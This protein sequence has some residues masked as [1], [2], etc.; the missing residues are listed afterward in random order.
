MV[1]R[2]RYVVRDPRFSRARRFR[3]TFRVDLLLGEDYNILL[4]S[5]HLEW[6]ADHATDIAKM[7]VVLVAGKT[8]RH[9]SHP[10]M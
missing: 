2:D 1:R 10:Q 3:V 5:R 7:V 6:I 8:I 9:A 4:G